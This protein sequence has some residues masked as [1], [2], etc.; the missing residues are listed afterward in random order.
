MICLRMYHSRE[1]AVPPEFDVERERLLV[2]CAQHD[3]EAFRELYRVYF[4]RVYSYVAYRLQR[5]PE[6]EDAVSEVFLR[7]I[8][9][10]PTFRHRGAGS[11]AAWIFKIAH[12]LISDSR[13]SRWR[14][15]LP[16]EA[17]ADVDDRQLQ[18]DLVAIHNEQSEELHRALRMLSPR[19]Q[20]I[21]GLKYFGGLRN[22]DIALVLGIGERAVASHLTRGLRDLQRQLQNVAH[23]TT[24]GGKHG[25]L[26]SAE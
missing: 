16:L 20:E 26:A 12:N 18:P 13:R 17:A 1:C 6:V 14:V 7:V 3:P 11:F 4:P 23:G 8:E 2:E 10:I 24:P 22:K 5:A 21:I 9:K 25:R 15:A 19:R